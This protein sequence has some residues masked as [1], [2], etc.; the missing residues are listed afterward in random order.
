MLANI[1]LWKK[2]CH[3]EFRSKLRRFTDL[4]HAAREDYAKHLPPPGRPRDPAWIE[5]ESAKRGN[6]LFYCDIPEADLLTA[7]LHGIFFAFSDAE[8]LSTAAESL[9]YKLL[10]EDV[11]RIAFQCGVPIGATDGD[12]TEYICYELE[13]ATPIIHGYP[14]AKAEALRILN[15]CP[16]PAVTDL[17]Q[18][19]RP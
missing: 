7:F 12:S 2:A 13:A 9:W 8:N 15:G 3:D 19:G 11:A 14:I 18:W 1:E 4:R 10:N 16:V 17:R 5:T 6:S